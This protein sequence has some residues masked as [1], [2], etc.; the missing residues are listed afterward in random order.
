M[1]NANGTI[2]LTSDIP[3]LTNYVTLNGTQTITGIKTFT[4]EQ[5]F[6]NGMTLTGGYITYTSGSFN[7]T[8]NTNLLTANRNVFLQDAAGT[9]AL[10]SDIPSL[11]NYVQNTRTISTTAPLS[12]GGDLSANRTLSISQANSTTNGFLSSTDW[13]TFNN[14]Q[15]ALTN[16]V[17]GT[18][19]TNT[20]A[21]FT[22]TSTIGNSM[23]SDDGTTLTSSGSTR[24]NLYLRAASNSFYSQLAFTNGTNGGFG[25]ISYNNSGQYMQFET[26]SS[27]WMRLTS[28]GKLGIN[29]TSPNTRLHV[30]ADAVY[31]SN[32][33]AAQLW[34]TGSDTAKRLQIGYDSTNGYGIIQAIHGG[35]SVKPLILQLQGGNVG[36]GTSS[37]N[38]LLE[39]R[40]GFIRLSATSGNGPQFNIYSNGQT[41]NHI[42]LAQ[43]FALATDNVGYLYNRANAD[44]VFGTNNSERM[45]ITSGGQLL[46]GS[47]SSLYP[48]V[49]LSV[50]QTLGERTAD[51]WSSWAGDQSTTALSIIKYDN[52]NTTSQIFV[53]FVIGDGN[54]TS[55]QIN[56]NGANQAAFGSWSDARLKENVKNL[57]SQLSNIMSLRPVEFDYK[58]GSGH[59]IG[60]IAQEMKEIYDDAIG[61]DE[62][63]YLTIT[64]WSKTEARLVKA[65]QE[66]NQLILELSAK[67]SALENKS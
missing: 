47:S 33:D 31:S 56:A 38:D 19:T 8:L 59:Q 10:L 39:V 12:G 49:K 60:F 37:P 21:K 57:P 67:V 3:S 22:G 41:S 35:V 34:V 23:L 2:A 1:P 29:T 53:R 28:D 25:G 27:E 44:F 5:L 40:G 20:H 7:L 54:Y 51:I 48:N 17:T 15:N 66:Q 55:G 45:R 11:S 43:G 61:E 64:G 13:N 65:I 6:G 36:I 62:N 58:D 32:W 18:G 50:K 52:V 16:P 14:K 26:N 42:T 46:V 4:N 30:A 24:S 9:I 63:G